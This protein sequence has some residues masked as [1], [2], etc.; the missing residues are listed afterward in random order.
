MASHNQDTS[1][2]TAWRLGRGGACSRPASVATRTPGPPFPIGRLVPV[3]DVATRESS[4]PLFLQQHP[5]TERRSG[6]AMPLNRERPSSNS[7]PD[8]HQRLI[9]A[10]VLPSVEISTPGPVVLDVA[11][12]SATLTIRVGQAI[13]ISVFSVGPDSN[14]MLTTEVRIELVRRSS[15]HLPVYQ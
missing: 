8:P 6:R 9:A 3:A 5:A 13:D 10:G 11:D 12:Q 7:A 14:P 15:I 4:Q 2:R 1:G